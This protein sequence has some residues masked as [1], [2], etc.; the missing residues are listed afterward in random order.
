MYYDH[1]YLEDRGTVFFET[2][3]ISPTANVQQENPEVPIKVRLN[4]PAESI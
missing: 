3:V 2:Y 4:V 1:F